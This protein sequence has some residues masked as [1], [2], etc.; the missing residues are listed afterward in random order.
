MFLCASFNGQN[1]IESDKIM[2]K[3][4]QALS[5]LCIKYIIFKELAKMILTKSKFHSQ[6]LTNE[7]FS[8]NTEILST[9]F[10][11]IEWR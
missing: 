6:T 9:L 2:D 5:N 8:L 4:T 3:F 1:R 10:Y 7:S 11:A